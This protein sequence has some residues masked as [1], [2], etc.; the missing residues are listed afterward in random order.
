LRF[1]AQILSNEITAHP[2]TFPNR[3][4]PRPRPKVLFVPTT[5]NPVPPGRELPK[6]DTPINEKVEM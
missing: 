6:L 4:N 1:L 5:D 3:L 2:V